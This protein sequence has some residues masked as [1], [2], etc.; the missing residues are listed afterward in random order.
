MISNLDMIGG[1]CNNSSAIAF[2]DFSLT[3]SEN[4]INCRTKPFSETYSHF[5]IFVCQKK[6]MDKISSFRL[7]P[8]SP[9]LPKWPKWS[10]GGNELFLQFWPFGGIHFMHFW[11]CHCHSVTKKSKNIVAL[12]HLVPQAELYNALKRRPLEM[13]SKSKGWNCSP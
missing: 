6:L 5:G 4:A 1:R 8:G 13:L 11:H 2:Y 3:D 10:S 12:G 7:S 9:K